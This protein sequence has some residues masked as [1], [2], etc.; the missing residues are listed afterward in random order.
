VNYFSLLSIIAGV[1]AALAIAAILVA[2]IVFIRGRD[3]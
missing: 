2:V 3:E 1:C